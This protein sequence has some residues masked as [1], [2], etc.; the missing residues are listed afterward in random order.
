MSEEMVAKYREG[1]DAMAATSVRLAEMVKKG[2]E[3]IR[4]LE[5]ALD[6]DPDGSGY[7]RFWSKKASEQSERAASSQSRL[8]EAVKVLEEI[9]RLSMVIENNVKFSES[10]Y[11]NTTAVM[12]AM[13]AAR[14][15]L[16]TLGEET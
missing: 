11:P 10:Y 6:S 15:F 4:E 3:R 1:F 13:G 8:S 2:D 9:N 12:F 16:A 7:W 5:A 14:Q